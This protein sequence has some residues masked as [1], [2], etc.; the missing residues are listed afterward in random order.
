MSIINF[1]LTLLKAFNKK[2]YAIKVINKFFKIIIF[3][4]DKLIK[5]N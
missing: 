2:D 1:V 3:I 4:F 5:F